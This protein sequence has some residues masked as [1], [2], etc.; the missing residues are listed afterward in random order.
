MEISK[1]DDSSKD[2]D[3]IVVKPPFDNVA[4]IAPEVKDNQIQEYSDD[5]SLSS[6]QPDFKVKTEC[7]GNSRALLNF[8]SSP[9]GDAKDPGIASDR[10]SENFKMNEAA[11]SSSQSS[12]HKAQDVDRSL[13]AVGDSHR[14][15][16]DESSSNPC[17]QKQELEGPENSLG[18]Q[19]S[20]SE[21]RYDFESPEEHSKPGGT[22]SNLPAVPSQ[23]KLGAIAGKSSSSSSTIL[24][25]KS[26][27][28]ESSKSA[29]ALNPNSIAKQQVIPD[30]NVSTRKDRPS[31]DV[32]DE[33]R[34]DMLRKIVKEH[35]KSFTNSAPK[36]SHS[37]RTHDSVSKQTTSESKDSGPFLS[38]KTSSAPSTAVTSGSSEPTGSLHHQKGVHLHNKNTASSILQKGEKMNQT[39][40][41][42]SS[43]I[44][45]NHASSMCPPAPSSSPAT[46]SDEEVS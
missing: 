37:S 36:P 1:L 13:E 9:Y 19:K 4:S 44:N 29:D 42:L 38:S 23:R 39:S 18:V 11:I 41:Q 35:A 3:R 22:M 14:D 15:N 43:K 28:S 25:A 45:Q 7:D 34:D 8:Q 16:A 30:C 6:E 46:L 5:K 24:I 2:P 17:Q 40:F 32:R 21:P 27:T 26:S 20:S 10:M 31:N 33:A 12:D